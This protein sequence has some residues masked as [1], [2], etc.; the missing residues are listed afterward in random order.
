MRHI[1]WNWK[2]VAISGAFVFLLALSIFLLTFS[3]CGT[4]DRLREVPRRLIKSIHGEPV[5]R[6]LIIENAKEFTVLVPAEGAK[7]KVFRVKAGKLFEDGNVVNGKSRLI[8][9]TAGGVLRV[10]KRGYRGSLRVNV[11]SGNTL[12]VINEIGLEDYLAGV[13]GSEMPAHFPE[14]ALCAQAIAARTY[15]LDRFLKKGADREYHLVATTADQVYKGTE[16]EDPRVRRI[17][18]RTRGLV[19]T[20]NG[21]IFTTYYHSTCGGHTVASADAFPWVKTTIPPLAGVPCGFCNESGR[22]SWSEQVKPD[23]LAKVK[24]MTRNA[25]VTGVECEEIDEYGR[26]HWIKITTTKGVVRRSA[27]DFRKEVGA[28]RIFSTRIDSIKKKGNAFEFHGRGW[29]HGVGMCQWG[30]CGMAKQDRDAA[31]I[32]KHYYPG[33]T[34]ERIY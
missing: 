16:N 14:E 19:L 34:I 11:R 6:I 21:D 28:R 22:Y 27:I 12:T 13:L 2:T 20:W 29:G 24:G 31:D 23:Q 4:H 18:D 30:A 8:K 10:G 33:A 26:V 32:L 15:S 3:S 7:K 1:R 9:P 17:V 5:V 25:R